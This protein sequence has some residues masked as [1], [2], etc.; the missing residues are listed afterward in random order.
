MNLPPIAVTLVGVRDETPA[1]L[2]DLVNP[3]VADVA[4]ARVPEPVPVVVEAILGER[5]H[6]RRAGPE[7]VVDAGRHRL[8]RRLA[9]GVAPLVAEPARHVDLAELA[10]AHLLH[11]LPQRR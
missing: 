7:V 11:G 3:L 5:A 10:F 4:V 9:D 6:R 2:V 1:A 8:D